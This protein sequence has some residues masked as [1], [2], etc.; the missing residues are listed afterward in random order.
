MSKLKI[1]HIITGLGMG[2]AEKVVL[3]LARL[4]DRDKWDVS[5]I[6]LD[7]SIDRIQ[8][9][10][11]E[12]I[13]VRSLSLSKL[14]YDAIKKAHQSSQLFKKEQVKIVHA[15]MTH[16]L[17]FSLLVKCFYP[18]LKIVYTS[19]TA[20][21]GSIWRKAIIFFSRILRA[22]DILFS[23]EMISFI[24]KK[25]VAIIPN[26]IESALYEKDK[27]KNK[28][29]TFIAIGRLVALKN[30]ELIIRAAALIRSTS[31]LPFEVHIVGAGP[32]EEEYQEL[33]KSLDLTAHVKL[34][35]LRK[36]IPE[37]LNQSHCFVLSSKWEGLPISLL[38]AA[39]AKLP[40]ISTAVGSIP[41]L[42]NEENGFLSSEAQF[43]ETMT[44]V[45]ENQTIA[46]AKAK[47]LNTLLK[48]K[49]ELNI[50]VAKHEKLYTDILNQ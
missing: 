16:G 42:I 10:E 2:G 41:D 3:D 50:I 48:A 36:D 35:G 40:V 29:F 13:L 23:N 6:S 27:I 26:G 33:I 44:H 45:L 32:L 4:T 47:K 39:A 20:N 14:P 15:H 43:A 5:I 21:V 9:F 28:R 30:Q 49:F 11:S 25:P 7:N 34:L 1:V 8:D 19:H 31:N 46:L 24:Y 22:K 37:L 17:I 38:E 18:K 12:D